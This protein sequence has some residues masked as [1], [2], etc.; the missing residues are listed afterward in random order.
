M[1]CALCDPALGPILWEGRCWRLV[2]NRNQDLLGKC[3][4]ALRRHCEAV[5]ELTDGEWQEL[6]EE[7]RLATAALAECFAPD[8]VNYVFLQNQDRHVHLHVVP[9]YTDARM[10]AGLTFDDPGYPGHYRVDGPP[11]LLDPETQ[12]GVADGLRQA[13]ERKAELESNGRHNAGTTRSHQRSAGC[14]G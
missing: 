8:H 12:Q 5:P 6:R 3:F 11:R 4:L 9:R 14:R 1:A 7:L 10:F 13:V 2:L